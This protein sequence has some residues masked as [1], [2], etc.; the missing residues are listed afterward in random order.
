MSQHASW[1]L[2]LAS[3][4]RDGQIQMGGNAAWLQPCG[5]GRGG[6]G[7]GPGRWC[8]GMC[9]GVK[10]RSGAGR[11][12]VTVVD[13]GSS[14]SHDTWLQWWWQR[15]PEVQVKTMFHLCGADDDGMHLLGGII[16]GAPPYLLGVFLDLLGE[17]S[18]SRFL[19]ERATAAS[20][21]LLPWRLAL[22]GD[23]LVR[24]GS[25]RQG[26]GPG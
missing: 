23:D 15:E 12:V 20:S 14:A 7:S 1:A 5:V 10:C 24:R 8:S 9:R 13:G 3:S 6:W 22:G 11:E 2:G 18:C 19:P 26:G 21:S 16:E 4:L 17:S 25:R